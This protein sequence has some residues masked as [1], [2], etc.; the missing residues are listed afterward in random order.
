MLG[1]LEACWEATGRELAV[2]QAEIESVEARGVGVVGGFS[3]KSARIGD[4]NKV[5]A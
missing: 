2:L 4:V 1:G 5:A 3:E